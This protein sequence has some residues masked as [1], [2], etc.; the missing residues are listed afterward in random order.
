MADTKISALADGLTAE[1]TD[2]I[3]IARDPTGT[4]LS[5]YV[6]PAYIAEY[7]RT[8]AQTLTNKTLTSPTLTAPA[9]GTPASGTLTNCNGLPLSTGISGLGTGIAT[10]L[11]INVGSAGAPVLFNGAGGTP[12]SLTLTNATGLPVG[13]ISATGT[14]SSSTFLRGDG[15]WQ[16]PAAAGSSGQLQYSNS[17]A[18]GGAN[19]WQGTNLI[20]QR[21]STTA[22]THAVY[23]TYTDASNY[24]RVSLLWSANEAFLRIQAAG[25]GV[26]TRGLKIYTPSSGDITLGCFDTARWKLEGSS[27]HWV[28]VSDD[29]YEM[30]T[31]ALRP[32]Y[33]RASR[34]IVT[35]STTVASLPPAGT[36]G[37]GAR[38]QVTDANAT[39]FQS[40]VAGGGA[41]VVPVYSDGT[42]WRIG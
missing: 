3:P 37:A 7:M 39:T 15:Q 19:L 29:T 30:G 35:P 31:A 33:V 24:E 6:T 16:A 18:F 8:L 26:T 14:P 28:P 5:R 2:R 20:E 38:S 34:A 17:G 21:N 12:S 1:A 10:A 41:N 32:R 40:I 9:L 42:N 11:A 13:G 4:P 25:T 22:Q 23:N 27:G 36:A